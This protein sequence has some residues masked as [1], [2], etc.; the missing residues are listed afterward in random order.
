MAPMTASILLADDDP[1]ILL[2]LSMAF[3]SA[4]HS[5]VQASDG[6][7]A[8][9]ALG[10]GSYD[11]LVLDILMPGATGWEVLAAAIGRTPPGSP[12]PRA[13]L[14]TGFNQEYVVDLNMLRQEGA[15][16]M[17]LKPFAATEILD[18]VQR[19]LALPP[20]PAP[21]RA[22]QGSTRY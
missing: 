9:E 8:I 13:I 2:T 1:A 3:K 22:V 10:Q 12:L 14:I 15:A 19:V 21:A 4:G 20:Q 16:G 17:L 7:K 18:E 5:V 6:A 11:L